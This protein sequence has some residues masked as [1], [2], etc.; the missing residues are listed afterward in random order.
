MQWDGVQSSPDL[1]FGL[2]CYV[3]FHNSWYGLSVEETTKQQGEKRG[4]IT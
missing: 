2:F 1:A 3:P 4:E